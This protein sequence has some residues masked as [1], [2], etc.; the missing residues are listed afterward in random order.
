MH[1]GWFMN[2]KTNKLEPVSLPTDVS[3]PSVSIIKIIQYD[4]SSPTLP[5]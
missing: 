5:H 2:D 4:S 1:T 3:P